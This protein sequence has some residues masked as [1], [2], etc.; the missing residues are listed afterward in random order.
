[1]S[2][3]LRRGFTLI[4]LLTVITIVAVL[5]AM[6]LP[7]VASV[8]ELAE[9]TTCSAQMRQVG[10]A[11]IVYRSDNEQRYPQVYWNDPTWSTWSSWAYAVTYDGR[12]QHALEPFIGTFRVF[13]CPTARKVPLFGRR[14]EVLDV[15]EGAIRRGAARGGGAPGWPTCLM[16]YNSQNWG[17]PATWTGNVNIPPSAAQAH[18]GPM[19]DGKTASMVQRLPGGRVDRCP[20]L[21]DGMWQ[22][23]GTNHINNQWG[24]YFPHRGKRANAIFNDGHLEGRPYGDFTSF[25]PVVQVR[26]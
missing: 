21:F 22:N 15:A 7:A 3:R 14:G 26:E 20:V 11:V 1:M 18:P 25:S 13:N 4:E 16:A 9:R 6:L 23:D 12:W 5:A 17:R 24:M 10:M 2:P 8:K 19:T